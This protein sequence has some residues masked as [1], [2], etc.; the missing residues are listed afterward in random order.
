MTACVE[1]TAEYYL[2]RELTL[3]G[4]RHEPWCRFHGPIHYYHDLLVGSDV[5]PHSGT[6]VTLG[7]DSRWR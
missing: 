2:E 6:E 5:L 4:D 7:S 1:R 3:Q